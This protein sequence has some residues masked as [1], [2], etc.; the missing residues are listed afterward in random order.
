MKLLIDLITLCLK[1]FDYLEKS[2]FLL[3]PAKLQV[4]KSPCGVAC[5]KNC[6]LL[7]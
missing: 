1:C 2:I 6:W 3:S 5:F 7:K 4:N